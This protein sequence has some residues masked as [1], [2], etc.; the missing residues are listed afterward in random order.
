[1]YIY[2]NKIKL[3]KVLENILIDLQAI[4]V[5][6]I[7]VGGCIR[8][9]LLGFP[10]K[11]YDIEIFS[12][13][14]LDSIEKVLKTHGSVKHVGKSF[15]VLILRVDG[16]DFDFAVARTERTTGRA[17]KHFEITTNANLTYK[18]AALRRDFTINSIGYDFFEDKLLDPYNGLEDLKN[19]ILRH[20]N[21]ETFMEDPLRVYR[22]VQFISRFNIKMHEKTFELCKKMVAED[23]LDHLPRERVFQEFKKLFLKSQKPSVGLSLLKDLGI[24]KHY[25]ELESIVGCEQDHEHHPEG[26]VWVH[27]LMTMDE[28]A[29]ILREEKIED[30]YRKLYLFYG[31]LCHDFGKPL[32][33]EFTDNGRVTSHRH[34]S[35]GIEPTISFLERLTSERKFID[36]VCTLVKN[37]LAPF[38]FYV[39]DSSLKA[40]K[41]LSL[42][43]NIEDL[44]LVCLADC[45]GRDIPDK[46]KCSKATNWLLE[47]AKELNIQN[48]AL[49]PLVQ[50]R[51]LIALGF[52]Q[53]KQFKELLDFAFDL[54]IEEHLQKDEIIEA[55]KKKYIL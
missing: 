5:K 22:G 16:Y 29:R 3:P 27:T 33:T 51:D 17:H 14:C 49:K 36:I 44:C 37:H 4:G 34:E 43:V 46:H 55:I 39:H 1:M 32:C 48:E 12:N 28:L 13:G 2:T 25:P 21:D 10:C 6:P 47:K 30:E 40:V 35:L 54:Q 50:G 23:D 38:Q 31:L 45:L 41:R 53:G 20:V 26:D 24:L 15:G 18:E 52:K 8:D 11:D 7:V 9:S 42:K 19:G